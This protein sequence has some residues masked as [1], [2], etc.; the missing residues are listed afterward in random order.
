MN[1]F[2]ITFLN[3]P[4]LIFLQLNDFGIGI[5]VVSFHILGMSPLFHKSLKICRRKF[6]DG[7]GN[8]FRN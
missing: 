3:K 5:T 1:I 8:S 6:V 4:E 2:L 7:S